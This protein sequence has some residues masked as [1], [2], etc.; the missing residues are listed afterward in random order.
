MLY[1]YAHFATGDYLVAAM[2]VRRATT[3]DATLI[4]SP[5]DL[6]G[7]Y[8]NRADYQAHL[9]KLDAHVAASPGD[10]DAKYLAGFARYAS[11]DPGGAGAIFAECMAAAP[12]DASYFIMRDAALRASVNQQAAERAAADE[13][14]SSATSTDP[15]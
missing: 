13:A 14:K 11:G 10:L 5:I 6:A 12:S 7:L 4:E 2:A 1:G 9:D 3:A 8:R 15:D